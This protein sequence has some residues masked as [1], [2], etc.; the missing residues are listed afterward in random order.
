MELLISM[1]LRKRTM[2]RFDAGRMKGGCHDERHDGQRH[3][4]GHGPRGDRRDHPDC[5][6]DRGAHQISVFP[7]TNAI[8]PNIL[9]L[10]A[11]EGRKHR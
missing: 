7:L 10:R 2:A 1:D 9:A 3:D 8:G 4:V 6:R 5:S 11:A